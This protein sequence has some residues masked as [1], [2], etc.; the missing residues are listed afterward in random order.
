MELQDF[1]HK[2]FPQVADLRILSRNWFLWG[3]PSRGPAQEPS[4]ATAG[5]TMW[6]LSKDS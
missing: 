6:F 4:R 3:P 1:N 5:A 2:N